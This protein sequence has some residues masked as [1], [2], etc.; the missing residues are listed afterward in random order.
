MNLFQSLMYLGGRPMTA[1]HNDDIEEPFP[2][3]YGNRA[4]SLRPFLRRRRRDHAEDR[5]MPPPSPR[6]CATC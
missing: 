6:I 1:G 4:V 3:A 5:R 2:R